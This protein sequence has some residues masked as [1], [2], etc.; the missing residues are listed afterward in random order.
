[1]IFEEF[2]RNYF[3]N[4]YVH[5]YISGDSI[6]IPTQQLQGKIV[7]GYGYIHSDPNLGKD[8]AITMRYQVTDTFSHTVD[9][10]GY[11]PADGTSPSQWIK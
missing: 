9:D 7:V 11:N 10:F 2:Y 1:M 4:G 3:F 8:G 5:G 6:Y